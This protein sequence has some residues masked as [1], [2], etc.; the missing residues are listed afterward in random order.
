[1]PFLDSAELYDPSTKTF[2]P[3]G[4]MTIDRGNHTASLLPNGKVLIASG[5]GR[6]DGVIPWV[7]LYD[8]DTGAFSRGGVAGSVDTVGPEIVSVL[9]NGQVLMS[10]HYYDSPS[11]AVRLYDPRGQE[12]A[13]TGN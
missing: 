12:F 6:T 1:G 3:T 9:T 4:T 5:Y 8:P 10:L 7:E 2:T 13:E 11:P